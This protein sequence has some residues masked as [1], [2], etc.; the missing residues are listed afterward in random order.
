MRKSSLPSERRKFYQLHQEGKSYAAI[1]ELY[2]YSEMC[3]RM[4]CRRQRDGGDVENRYY[5]P[6]SGTLSQF[7]ERV[8]QRTEQM[9]RE[10]PGWGPE[11][12]L[13]HLRKEEALAGLALPSRSSIGRYLHSFE[14]FR[15]APKKKGIG[16]DRIR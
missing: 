10:H 6:R 15:R 5:N 12:I 8:R 9:K 14:A 11:S 13:L 16:S 4:W 2:G 7:D 1:G 3:V